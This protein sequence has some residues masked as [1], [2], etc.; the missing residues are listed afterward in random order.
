M[1]AIYHGP[2][3]LKNIAI[4]VNTSAHIAANI[5]EHYGFTLHSN[6]KT[7]SSFF[8]TFTVV[9]CDAKKLG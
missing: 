6:C 1:Y 2:E 3:G 7:S 5:F 8:D 9:G 4:R